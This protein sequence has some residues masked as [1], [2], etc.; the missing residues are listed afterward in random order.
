M[1]K[2]PSLNPVEEWIAEHSIRIFVAVAVAMLVC[3]GFIFYS[4]DKQGSTQGQVNALK[5]QVTQVVHE[6]A[7]CNSKVLYN[8]RASSD[9]ARRIHIGLTNCR[10]HPRCRAAFLALLTYPPPARPGG[11][12]PHSPSTAG[13][14]PTPGSHPGGHAGGHPKHSAPAK[15][16]PKKHEVP[17]PAPPPPA[18][19]AAPPASPPPPS[20]PGHS[21]EHPGAGKGVKT[22]VEL[23]VSACVQ[24]EVGE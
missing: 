9:C 4:L 18:A 22:C 13:Q 3:G 21:G 20:E 2:T 23:V 10:R 6:A 12:M 11:V 1:R 14:Q 8:R 15:K 7:I 24:A 19:P 5:P 16:P 17:A